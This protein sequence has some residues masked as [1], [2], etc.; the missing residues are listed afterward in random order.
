MLPISAFEPKV[1]FKRKEGGQ[2]EHKYQFVRAA[3]IKGKAKLIKGA[4]K[5]QGRIWERRGPERDAKIGVVS[6]VGIPSMVASSNVHPKVEKRMQEVSSRTLAHE[7]NYQ[8]DKATAKT[9]RAAR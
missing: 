1:S 4:F 8:L 2:T 3:I 5:A 6:T 7:V 9:R